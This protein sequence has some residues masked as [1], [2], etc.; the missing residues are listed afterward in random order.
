MEASEEDITSIEGIGPEIAGSVAA[1]AKEADSRNLV[2]RLGA[3]GVRLADPEP[4]EPAADSQLLAGL[5]FVVTGTLDGFSRNDARALIEER[6]GKVTGSVS[7]KTAALI[8]G[9]SPGSKLAK[10]QQLGIPVLDEV[11]FVALLQNGPGSSSA[12]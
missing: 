11:A 6:G 8:A 10:A 5:S 4:A 9:A 3:A 12:G 7:G 1:W 2:D